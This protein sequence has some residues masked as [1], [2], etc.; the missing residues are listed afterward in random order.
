MGIEENL[1]ETLLKHDA[2][3]NEDSKVAG[4]AKLAVDR[5]FSTLSPAQKSVLTP[6]MSHACEG[7]TD[8]GEHHN[9]CNKVLEG[10]ELIEAYDHIWEHDGIVCEDCR[11]QSD[12]DDY[13][14]QKFMDE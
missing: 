6:F 12:Y 7:Y 3:H 10:A 9:D 2:F 11:E 5:G 4:I 13:R 14:R 1:L 8:P